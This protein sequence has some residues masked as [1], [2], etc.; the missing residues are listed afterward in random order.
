[1]RCVGSIC[2]R[3]VYRST[4]VAAS[5]TLLMKSCVTGALGVAAV[6]ADELTAVPMSGR[7]ASQGPHEPVGAAVPNGMP[8]LDG[9]FEN[10]KGHVGA[11]RTLRGVA[12]TM[13]AAR[14][15]RKT[16]EYMTDFKLNEGL[17]E[18]LCANRRRRRNQ[19]GI[20]QMK[21]IVRFSDRVVCSM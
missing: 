13:V 16:L 7:S 21:E 18:R 20:G 4:S 19:A 10:G 3:R 9:A 15:A 8:V 6:E 11:W 1:L 5:S 12:E 17:W 14:P 2:E